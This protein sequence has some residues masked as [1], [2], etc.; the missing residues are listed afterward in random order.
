MTPPSGHT[1]STSNEHNPE[2]KPQKSVFRRTR[3]PYSPTEEGYIHEGV[4]K[5]GKFWKQILYTYDFHPSRTAVDL[6]DKY[7]RMTVSMIDITCL[8]V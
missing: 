3:I 1:L 5:L 7:K 2:F 4:A 6:M 8:L